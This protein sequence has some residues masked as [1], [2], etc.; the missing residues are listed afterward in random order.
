MSETRVFRL[1]VLL[2][3]R[4]SNFA[5]IQAA[6]E[7]GN[8]PN[9]RVS[10]AI[11]NHANAQ[12]L[13]FAASKEIPAFA[14]DK[15]EFESRIAFDQAIVEILRRHQVDLV[16]LAGYDRI[17]SAPLLEAYDRRILN[18]HPSLLPAYGGKGMVGIKVHQTVLT[19]LEEESGCSVHLVTAVVDDGPVLGQS[20]V[21]VM[22]DDTPETLASRVLAEEHRLYPATIGK[23]IESVLSQEGKPAPMTKPLFKSAKAVLLMG[24]IVAAGLQ[25]AGCQQNV[26]YQ[27]S[28]SELNQKAQAMLASGDVDGAVSRLEAAHDLQPDEP[29]TAYNLAIA[30]QTQGS[31]DKAIPLLRQL[32]EKPQLDTAQVYKT[33]GITYETKADELAGKAREETEKP[34][35]DQ[36]KAQQMKAE[37]LES[38]QLAIDSYRQALPGLKNTEAVQTQIE[39][40]EARLKQGSQPQAA[41]GM[42]TP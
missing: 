31:Y 32:V 8:I 24:A 17:I 18:I 36:A 15:S 9:T 12:G 40:L 19:N 11:S 16:I 4:G 14:L 7:A 21:P 2:S 1:G 27:R 34:K 23:Y 5:A 38:Y 28:M 37:S 25:L 42:G 10:V 22:A 20:R 29:N 35:P 39:A 41:T 26:V 3:G 6:I 30:Y 13:Q 33:L